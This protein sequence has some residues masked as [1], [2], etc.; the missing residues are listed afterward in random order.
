MGLGA[1]VVKTLTNDKNHHVYF[2]NYF[3]SVQRA[4]TGGTRGG[5]DIQF[6]HSTERQKGL[7]TR[8]KKSWL[9]AE[10]RYYH[11]YSYPN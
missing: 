11:S 1:H 9:E 2:D 3:T 7:S 4:A 5:W 10:V 6:W 8:P